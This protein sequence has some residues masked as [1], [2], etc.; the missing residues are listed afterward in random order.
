MG[1]GGW[2]IEA[3]GMENGR[4]GWRMGEGSEEWRMGQG[5]E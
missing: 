3:G 1:G 2:R 5:R 4:W